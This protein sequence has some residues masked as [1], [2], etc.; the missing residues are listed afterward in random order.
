MTAPM[1]S[2]ETLEQIQRETFEYFIHLENPLNGLIPDRTQEDS[3][4]SITVVGL[5][6][7]SY[8]V[9]VERRFMTARKPSNGR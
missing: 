8:P 1:M 4:A 3:P 2:H 7:S 6:L 9:G 5:A